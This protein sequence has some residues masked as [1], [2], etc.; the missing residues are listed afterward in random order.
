MGVVGCAIIGGDVTLMPAPPT[1]MGEFV[2]VVVS[3][4]A[5]NGLGITTLRG[6]SL[7]IAA[8]AAMFIADK[9]GGFVEN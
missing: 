3:G 2:A 8:A 6:C 1:A 5:G 9:S 7:S 4:P